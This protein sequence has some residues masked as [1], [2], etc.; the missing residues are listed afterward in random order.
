MIK[1]FNIYNKNEMRKLLVEDIEKIDPFLSKSYIILK[2]KNGEKIKLI[3]KNINEDY[4]F[5]RKVIYNEKE[6]IKTSSNRIQVLCLDNNIIYPNM[7]ECAKNFNFPYASFRKHIK[8]NGIYKNK[9]FKL[10]SNKI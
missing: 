5:L 8:K 9:K 10:L 7:K 4:S 3:L 6:T 2:L 1:Y